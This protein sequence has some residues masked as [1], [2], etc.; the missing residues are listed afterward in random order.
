MKTDEDHELEL[1]KSRF[2]QRGVS[3]VV[4]ERPR[5]SVET[6]WLLKQWEARAEAGDPLASDFLAFR[7]AAD[8]YGAKVVLKALAEDPDALPPLVRLAARLEPRL[9][10]A[11]LAAAQRA[12]NTAQLERLAEAIAAGQMTAAEAYSGALALSEGFKEPLRLNLLAG[13]LAGA[14]HGIET[15]RQQ[16]VSPR[17]DLMNP[18]AA[19]Y[20][21]QMSVKLVQDVKANAAESVRS[22]IAEAVE[23]G[24]T[25]A[26]TAQLIRDANIV[27]LHPRQTGAFVK[28]WEKLQRDGVKEDVLERRLQRYGNALLRQRSLT[29]ART[30][31]MTAANGGQLAAWQDARRQGLIDADTTRR[32]SATSDDRTDLEVCLPLDG[33]EATLDGDFVV[34]D[35]EAKG[36]AFHSPPAHPNCLVSPR[37]PVYTSEGWKA[38]RDVAIGDLVLTHKGRF[39]VVT[40][41]HRNQDTLPTIKFW[42]DGKR[43]G[44]SLTMNHPILTQ[45]GWIEAGQVTT[46]DSVTLIGTRC[47]YCGTV[48]PADRKSKVKYCNNSCATLGAKKWLKANEG[49]RRRCLDGIFVLQKPETKIKA[50]RALAQ[51]HMGTWLERKL[52]WALEQLDLQFER[53]YPI[54]CL[55][56]D[57]LGRRK[58]WFVGFAFPKLK[59]AI[60]CD[61][62]RWHQDKDRD[63]RRQAE[64]E[65]QGW[66]VLRFTDTAIHGNARACA[67]QIARIANNHAREYLFTNR[68]IARIQ[69]LS[70]RLRYNTYNLSVEDDESYIASGVAVHNCRCSEV[71][72]AAK[73]KDLPVPAVQTPDAVIREQVELGGKLAAMWRAVDALKAALLAPVRKR[74]ERGA[75]GRLAVIEE[76]QSPTPEA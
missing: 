31:T 9:R 38:V 1:F 29:I 48:I 51:R 35:G 16:G 42:F 43:Q 30:E 75:D 19:S 66:T 25:P 65:A 59:L 60:E 69:I 67:E 23:F 57:R 74:V 18:H 2:S 37:T 7:D 72:V 6:S 4:I 11:F 28:Y 68:R 12:Q 21:K 27:G 49:M 24:V 63:A 50:N 22:F 62:A 5:K 54:Q 76:R 26:K 53:A 44:L 3:G 10:R 15:L 52:Q 17:F 61:G 47:G 20:A 45:R 73:K 8:R 58:H 36:E 34:P 70:R 32:W 64:L 14:G 56:R 71:L 40:V 46:D 41:L 13:F 39:K 55:H 33:E